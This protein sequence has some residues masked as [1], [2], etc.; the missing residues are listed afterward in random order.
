MINTILA[1]SGSACSFPISAD[2][3]PVISG[4]EYFKVEFQFEQ[5]TGLAGSEGRTD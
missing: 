2:I 1:I 5:N 4:T 3:F